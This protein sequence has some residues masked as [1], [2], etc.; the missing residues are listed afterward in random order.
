MIDNLENPA[1]EPPPPTR[2]HSTGKTGVMLGVLV[3]ALAALAFY[4][5][6]RNTGAIGEDGKRPAPAVSQ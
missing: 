4:F 3:V 6:W 1:Q 2:S 5:Y